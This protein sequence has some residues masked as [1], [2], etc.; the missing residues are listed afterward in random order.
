MAQKPL[1]PEGGVAQSL[2]ARL[3]HED[4]ARLDEIVR[5][6]GVTR[7]D[8]VRAAVVAYI[9]TEDASGQAS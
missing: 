5:R 1:N 9:D 3:P 8:V 7:S 4:M 6:R 2:R